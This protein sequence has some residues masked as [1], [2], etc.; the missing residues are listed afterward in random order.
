VH[1]QQN[2]DGKGLARVNVML[3]GD[4]LMCL[5][6][7]ASQIRE[8]NGAI[9]N[10]SELIRAIVGAFAD[11]NLTIRGCRTETEIREGLFRYLDR[12][13]KSATR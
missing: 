13:T 1:N 2:R 9:I 3:S 12:L 11:L 6:R 4:V 7:A 10:R 8:D 5:E